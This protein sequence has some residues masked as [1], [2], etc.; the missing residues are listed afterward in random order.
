MTTTDY[1]AQVLG[2]VTSAVTR[3]AGG[4]WLEVRIAKAALNPAIPPSA[5]TI[6]FDFTARDNDANNTSPPQRIDI[7]RQTA[8]LQKKA[9]QAD[10]LAQV[11]ARLEAD[12]QTALAEQAA[13]TGRIVNVPDLTTACGGRSTGTV[14]AASAGPPT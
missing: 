12:L 10:E 13:K 2:G 11:K 7:T 5:G 1:G 4:W 9:A 6:G 8:D 3:D 14:G